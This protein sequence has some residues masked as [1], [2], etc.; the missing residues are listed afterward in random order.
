MSATIAS[1][2]FPLFLILRQCDFGASRVQKN[3]PFDLFF[4][5][6]TANFVR[7]FFKK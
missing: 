5:Q 1:F 3:L 7:F 4:S 2:S 6:M